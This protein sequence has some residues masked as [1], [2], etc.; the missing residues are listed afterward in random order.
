M[1]ETGY[2]YVIVGAGSAGCVLANRLSVDPDCRVLLL[3]A[4]GR[5]SNVWLRLPVG[6]FRTVLD[7]RFSRL[8]ETEPEEGTG[9]RRVVWPRG[10]VLGGSSSIN[11]LVFVRGEPATFDDWE[12]MGATGW[13]ARDVL[14]A[15][16][17]IECFDGPEESQARGAHGELRVSRL[18][19]DHPMCRAWIESA[20][21]CGHPFNPDFNAGSTRG[22]GGYQLTLDRRF[23]MSA[24]RAF[25]HPVLN[26]PNLTVETGAFV[27]RVI[28]K[29]GRATGVEWTRDGQVRRAAARA[30]VILSAGAVQS[31]QL[32]QLS[33]IGPQAA[34]RRAGVP[35]RLDR[36]AVGGN[37]QDHYQMRMILRMRDRR[38]LNRQTRNPLWLA[39]AGLDWLLRGRGPLT[40]GAGQVGGAACTSLADPGR[41]DVQMIV[42]PLSADRVGEPLHRFPG[43]SSTVWQCHPASRGRVDIRSDEATEAPEIRPN[44][45]SEE[46]DRRTL[47]EG[48]RMLR[49]IHA[50][51]P[52]RNLLETEVIPG[53][54]AHDDAQIL[55]AIRA[56]AGTVFHPCGTCRMGSDAD[57]P[58]D[59][60][61]RVNGV[62]RLRVVDASVMPLIPSGNINAATLM[63]AQKAAPLILAD[64]GRHIN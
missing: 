41:P 21:A 15:F 43:F 53:G 9:G 14:P 60:A 42:M 56:R 36:A 8:F 12:R 16:R 30:E 22:V 46:V 7:P 37:L 5:D 3:E 40:I 48:V 45:L 62:E 17:E 50:A 31:P 35:V 24:A 27:S 26:R 51:A 64:A 54:S 58:T 47:I 28:L 57:A 20:Q 61:L 49:E 6:Y 39:G 29:K 63:V 10:R 18:R 32:L 25:L 11:G 13:S 19:H 38:S 44:Y 4:G 34:L 33:G 23:R 1:S 55:D 2:D 52:F 59:P